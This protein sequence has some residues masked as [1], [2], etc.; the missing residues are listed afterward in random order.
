MIFSQSTNTIQGG[1]DSFFQQRVLGKLD[2]DMQ[3]NESRPLFY[4]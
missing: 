4:T 2:I 3:M 1:K